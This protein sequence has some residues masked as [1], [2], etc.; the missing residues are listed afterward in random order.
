MNEECDAGVMLSDLQFGQTQALRPSGACT[1]RQAIKPSRSQGCS[2][3]T[4]GKVYL[5]QAIKGSQTG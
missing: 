4:P 2:H 5:K 3:T 1:A